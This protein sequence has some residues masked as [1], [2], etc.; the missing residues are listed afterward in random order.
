MWLLVVAWP[1]IPPTLSWRRTLQA[2]TH[3]GSYGMAGMGGTDSAISL[4]AWDAIIFVGQTTLA[5]AHLR[6]TTAKTRDLN[7]AR[8]FSL[9]HSAPRCAG[10]GLPSAHLMSFASCY[11]AGIR[12]IALT[13]SWPPVPGSSLTRTSRTRRAACL[14]RAS[15][16]APRPSS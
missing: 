15:K 13:T 11:A 14:P 8:A 3:H 6:D 4:L 7:L 9:R 12:P 5:S 2:S 10:L 16:A 1:C